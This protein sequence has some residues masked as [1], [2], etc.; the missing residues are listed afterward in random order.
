MPVQFL[1]Q[2]EDAMTAITSTRPITNSHRAPLR[3]ALPKFS[4]GA[5][6]GQLA[7]AIGEA[8][9]MLYVAPYQADRP[10]VGAEVKSDGRDPSW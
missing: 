10:R 3:L 6:I 8:F 2:Q 1:R 7:N 4:V 5:G 9:T